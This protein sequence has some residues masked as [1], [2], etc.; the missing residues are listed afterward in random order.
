MR[1]MQT[2][3]FY[4]SYL[5]NFYRHHPDLIQR[6]YDEQMAVLRQDGFCAGQILTPYL[7]DHGFE[8]FLAVSN[9]LPAQFRWAEDHGLKRPTTWSELMAVTAAQIETFKPDVLYLGDPLLTDGRFVRGLSWKPRLTLTWRQASIPQGT[10]WRG[11]DLLLSGDESCRKRGLS[12]GVPAA[13]FYRPGFPT[14]IADAVRHEQKQWDVVF[15]GQI[16]GEHLQRLTVL[17]RLARLRSDGRL[18]IDIGYFLACQDERV[19]P[20][21][22][23]TLNKGAV[24]GMEMY[25]TLRRARMC[26]NVHIDITGQGVNFRVLESAGCGTFQLTEDSPSLAAAFTPGDEVGVYRDF[27][28]L[29]ESVTHYL[30]HAHEREAIAERG[31]R[32]CLADHGMEGRAAYFADMIRRRAAGGPA[33]SNGSIA[34]GAGL[35]RQ[36]KPAEARA[37]LAAYVR[38]GCEEA[39]AHHLLGIAAFQTG[40]AAAAVNAVRLAIRLAPENALYRANLS[41]ILAA[42]GEIVKARAVARVAMTLNPAEAGTMSHLA[43]LGESGGE[44]LRRRAAALMGQ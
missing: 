12:L 33:A 10:D 9:F 7:Q 13:E 23:R 25:R 37:V 17:E 14:F 20:E 16:T 24:W 19:L 3:T 30:D 28:H 40:D 1:L 36:N 29:V 21:A 32:R 2:F 42:A 22:V 4:E 44:N 26:L 5:H 35:I 38:L 43:N 8:T 18:P 15:T 27:D 11:I 31:Q 39:E 6:P 41:A 34:T